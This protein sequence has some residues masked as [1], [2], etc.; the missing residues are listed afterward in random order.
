MISFF[1]LERYLIQTRGQMPGTFVLQIAGSW[2]SWWVR[3]MLTPPSSPFSNYILQKELRTP[4]DHPYL[5]HWGLMSHQE[6]SERRG[7][8]WQERTLALFLLCPPPPKHRQQP[9]LLL[10]V[11]FPLCLLLCYCNSPHVGRKT[12]TLKNGPCPSCCSLNDSNNGGGRQRFVLIL[13]PSAP[14]KVVKEM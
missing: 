10:S 3:V 5:L 4:D 13:F 2:L 11:S 8:H 14:K 7:K 12:K 9:F 1:C 6:H